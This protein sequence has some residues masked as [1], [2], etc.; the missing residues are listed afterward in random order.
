MLLAKDHDQVLAQRR[1]RRGVALAIVSAVVFVDAC[2][3]EP[4]WL[5]TTQIELATRFSRSPGPSL[6]VALVSDLHTEGLG[7]VER[8]A[9]ASVAEARADV[10]VITGDLIDH[11]RLEAARPVLAALVATKPRLG[12]WAVAG[13]WEHWRPPSGDLGRFYAELGI[14][15]LVDEARPL[16][17]SP[18]SPAGQGIWIAGVDWEGASEHVLDRVPRGAPVLA[19]AHAPATFDVLRRQAERGDHALLVLA[20]HT[21][22]GQVRLPL[23]GPLWLP[24]GSG[25]YAAGAFGSSRA[26]LYVSRG[27][28]TSLLPVR[29][30]CRP[31]LPILEL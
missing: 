2:V 30:F 12:T 18:S 13:N 28:G 29:F 8:Q 4:R 15:L 5:D 26:S 14:T 22:G 6:H 10:V 3:V 16:D 7:Y 27:I 19:L 31:E 23:I 11:G 25:P 21:H 24:P 9:V 17:A 20:G 1:R